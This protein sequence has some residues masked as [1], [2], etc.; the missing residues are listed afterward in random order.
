[1]T[2]GDSA[3]DVFTAL[4]KQLRLRLEKTTLPLEVLVIE[5]LERRPAEN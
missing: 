5:Q 1:V 2:T 4:E 3:P